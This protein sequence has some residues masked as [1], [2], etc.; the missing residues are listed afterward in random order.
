[1]SLS[2]PSTRAPIAGPQMVPTPPMTAGRIAWIETL[3][4]KATSGS[5]KK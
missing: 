5:T 1:M 3:G 4:P 2:G